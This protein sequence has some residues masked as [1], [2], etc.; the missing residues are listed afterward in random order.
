[1]DNLCANT[2]LYRC[3]PATPLAPWKTITFLDECNYI[4]FVFKFGNS[5]DKIFYGRDGRQ[6]I[7]DYSHTIS[8]DVYDCCIGGR[9]KIVLPF[10]QKYWTGIIVVLL[11]IRGLDIDVRAAYYIFGTTLLFLGLLGAAYRLPMLDIKSDISYGVYIY[12]MT[13]VNALIE[14]GFKGYDWLLG[15]VIV[16]SFILAW[17]SNMTVGKWGLKMKKD[18]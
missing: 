1:M 11:I 13:I 4:R 6:T 17:I 16:C 10:L 2:I 15:I 18:L 5:S 3:L 7:W 8:L 12:H 9:K 14:I